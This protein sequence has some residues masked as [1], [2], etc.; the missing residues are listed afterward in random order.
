MRNL[1]LARQVRYSGSH[2][3]HPLLLFTFS[4]S[5]SPPHPL[6]PSHRSGVAFAALVF[7]GDTALPGGKTQTETKG[8]L[9]RHLFSFLNSLPVGR[10]LELHES[11][12]RVRSSK[13]EG[14]RRRERGRRPKQPRLGGGVQLARDPGRS[15]L[16][17]H[18]QV[19][20]SP[21]PDPPYIHPP[22]LFTVLLSHLIPLTIIVTIINLFM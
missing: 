22:P 21:S 2:H 7:G 17:D 1:A 6:T 10:S 11:W 12:G 18:P 5:P 13:S 9:P 8:P 16:R 3:P 20:F 14:V 4:S 15:I 19:P